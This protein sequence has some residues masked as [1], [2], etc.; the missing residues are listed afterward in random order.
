M[1][2]W[3][4]AHAGVV[5]IACVDLLLGMA[6]WIVLACGRVSLAT[7]AFAAIGLSIA[8]AAL[9]AR[10]PAMGAVAL[11]VLGAGASSYVMG[12]MLARVDRTRFTLATVVVGLT[13][14][15]LVERV[16]LPAGWT[17]ARA[18]VPG[19]SAWVVVVTVVCLVVLAL[20]L[21]SRDGA[22][23][24]AVAQDERAA[25][26]LGI[27][28]PALRCL[29]LT[30]GGAL[31]GLAG[32]IAL[33]QHATLGFAPHALGTGIH[34][35]AIAVVGGSGDM[36]GPI[37]GTAVL[38]V[39]EGYGSR[40]AWSASIVDATLLL[41]ACVALPGGVSSLVRSLRGAR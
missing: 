3:A 4:T 14:P 18:L 1:S 6:A 10:W 27:N 9:R 20:I 24:A 23:F 11:G 2:V 36:F 12:L 25:Q 16:P 34:A 17:S 38:G 19:T 15:A 29:A 5:T 13:V 8:G 32:V 22:A 30:L 28:A 26:T 40:F 35:L 31:A 7:P 37:V 21:R 33:L 39:A 41:V